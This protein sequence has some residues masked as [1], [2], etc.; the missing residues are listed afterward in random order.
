MID[1]C[2]LNLTF[3]AC[4]TAN[5]NNYIMSNNNGIGPAYTNMC[6]RVTDKNGAPFQLVGDGQYHNYTIEWHTGTSPC[7]RVWGLHH[8]IVLYHRAGTSSA[9][10]PTTSAYVNFFIDGIYMGTNNAFVP[11]R[12]G[13]LWL[14]LLPA[15]QS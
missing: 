1:A 15:G 8:S 13:R 6:V 10:G 12:A 5:F 14:S 11:T 9:G 4:S 3:S 2:A 7:C